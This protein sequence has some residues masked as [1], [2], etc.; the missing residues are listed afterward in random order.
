MN[1]ARIEGR[2][3]QPVSTVSEL[4]SKYVRQ[5]DDYDFNDSRLI[6]KLGSL[7]DNE[8]SLSSRV[9]V[10]PDNTAQL[11]EI[12]AFD[13]SRQESRT[14]VKFGQL[15]LDSTVG[16]QKVE[17]VAVKYTN[18]TLAS[19]EFV[20]TNTLSGTGLNTFTPLGF[21][22]NDTDTGIVSR[23]QHEIQTLDNSL[24]S[25]EEFAR[26]AKRQRALARTGVW[27]ATL[28]AHNFVHGDAQPKNVAF[29]SREQPFYIDLET[30]SQHHQNALTLRDGIIGDFADF[31]THQI[32]QLPK[33][34]INTILI[35]SYMDT[36]QNLAENPV[37]RSVDL[38]S[39]ADSAITPLARFAP[40][41][42]A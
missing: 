30:A 20:A 2:I 24:W 37:I 32:H 39:I 38:D 26:T 17:H 5:V 34:E 3:L 11:V 25:E 41:E 28:H 23:Y 40:K 6:R 12:D 14:G 21:I 27:L 8:L 35:P 18:P 33:D 16:L 13:M 22:K 19:R 9:S 31:T 36:Y 42:S 1:S 7:G 4:K 29:D 10:E 15:A